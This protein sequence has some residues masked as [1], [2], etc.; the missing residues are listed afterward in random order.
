MA[1]YNAFKQS[2]E[3][4]M[5]CVHRLSHVELTATHNKK[6]LI[7]YLPDSMRNSEVISAL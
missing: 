4:E 1:A 6:K 7:H 3:S 5:I 2:W